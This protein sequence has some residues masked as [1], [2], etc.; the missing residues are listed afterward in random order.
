VSLG[1]PQLAA[2]LEPGAAAP[3]LAV[4]LVPSGVRR[5]RSAL[6]VSLRNVGSEA[7]D[8]GGGEWNYVQI[9]FRS[10]A[11]G[12]VEPGDFAGWEQLWQGRERRTLRAL[13]EAD[14]LRL[15]APF[16]GAGETLESGPVELRAAAGGRPEVYVSGRF[17]LPGGRELAIARSPAQWVDREGRER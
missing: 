4:E 7:T 8:L 3:Q 10:G 5:G 16:V 1:P 15:F 2:A 14:T 6:R 11:L 12:R 13:R 17:L 9:E